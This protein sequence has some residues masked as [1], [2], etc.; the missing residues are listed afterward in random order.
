MS[1]EISP[2][3]LSAGGGGPSDQTSVEDHIEPEV[4]ALARAL[5]A[6]SVTLECQQAG[7]PERPP[8]AVPADAQELW[9]CGSTLYGAIDGGELA[10][11][12]TWTRTLTSQGG[13]RRRSAATVIRGRF[14]VTL[15][16]QAVGF[17]GMFEERCRTLFPSV[18]ARRIGRDLEAMGWVRAR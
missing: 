16:S 7:E 11:S 2:S 8:C 4:L 9:G 6:S 17:A 15:R 12:V 13:E 1:V 18:T 14:A 3:W 5:A 10:S